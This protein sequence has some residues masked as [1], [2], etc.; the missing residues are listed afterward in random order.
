MKTLKYYTLLVGFLIGHTIAYAQT[1]CIEGTIGN[2]TSSSS[3]LSTSN[4]MTSTVAFEPSLSHQSME[5]YIEGRNELCSTHRLQFVVY[6]NRRR[7]LAK[8]Y[9][10]TCYRSNSAFHFSFIAK[11]SD[12]VVIRARAVPKPNTSACSCVSLGTADFDVCRY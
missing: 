6:V 4:D 2:A 10:N 8:N 11:I 3:R 7:V 5:Y 1:N 9:A 12:H